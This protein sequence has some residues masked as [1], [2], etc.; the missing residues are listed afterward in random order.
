MAMK[1]HL[2]VTDAAMWYTSVTRIHPKSFKTPHGQ[3]KMSF[4]DNYFVEYG[5]N[6]P[7]QSFGISPR[8]LSIRRYSVPFCMIIVGCLLC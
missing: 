3:R 1:P 5:N 6:Y 2:S 8:Q 4:I 7:A